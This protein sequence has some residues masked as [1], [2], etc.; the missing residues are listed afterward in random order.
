MSTN[1][2][3]ASG[4]SLVQTHHDHKYAPILLDGTLKPANLHIWE[5]AAN[6]YFVKMKIVETEKVLNICVSF[7][8]LGITNWID[9]SKDTIT[10]ED[11]DFASFMSELREQFLE[12]GWAK[13][14]YRTEIK[15]EMEPNQGFAEWANRVIY[16]NIIL[17][18]TDNHDNGGAAGHP[19]F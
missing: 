15:R 14:L 13:K 17:K 5:Q 16:H 9:G 18:G 10:A 2:V 7:R 19:V 3:L 8:N 1:L 4:S 11:Y 12:I 6:R